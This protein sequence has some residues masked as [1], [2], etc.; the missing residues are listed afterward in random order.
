MFR[1]DAERLTAGRQDA[2]CGCRAQQRL[3]KP[4]TGVD[5]VLAV[6]EHQQ[7][8][9]VAQVGHERLGRAGPVPSRV[10]Q[11]DR[12]A[13]ALRQ[14]VGLPQVS[15]FDDVDAVGEDPARVTGHPQG[16]PGLAHAADPGQRDQAGARQQ[17]S[18]PGG[19]GASADQRGQFGAH[20]A[21]RRHECSRS[22]ARSL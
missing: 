1:G 10:G 21:G 15:Q 6:V 9:S 20:A 8:L 7:N 5:E 13:E 14:E 2:H 4:G 3:D 16:E 11:A 18:D 22:H 17:P 12:G 19:L